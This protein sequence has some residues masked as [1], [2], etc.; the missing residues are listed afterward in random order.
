[1]KYYVVVD[2]GCIECG[3]S[4]NILGIFENEAKA[5][6]ILKDHEERQKEKWSGQHAFEIFE[7]E[8]LNKEYRVEY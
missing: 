7:I 3:E 6:E 8:E 5:G 1:M 2:I 4:T